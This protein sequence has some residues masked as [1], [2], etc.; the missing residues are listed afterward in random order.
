MGL[1]YVLQRVYV[2]YLRTD[3][4]F[5]G[6][7]SSNCQLLCC[8][9]TENPAAEYIFPRP[10]KVSPRDGTEVKTGFICCEMVSF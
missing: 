5:S 7:P 2:Q 1:I 8:V 9:E 10:R 6:G 4:C 3:A